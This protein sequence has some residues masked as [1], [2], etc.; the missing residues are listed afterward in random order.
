M[1]NLMKLQQIKTEICDYYC[2]F[3]DQ[4]SADDQYLIQENECI[5]CPLNQL[6][7]DDDEEVRT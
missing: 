5:K 1:R 6:T 2:K 3:P 4:Y 7:G